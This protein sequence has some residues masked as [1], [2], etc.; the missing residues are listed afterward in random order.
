MPRVATC[1]FCN[2]RLRL[3]DDGLQGSLTCPLC[4]AELERAAAPAPVETAAD[5][6]TISVEPAGKT[7]PS[8]AAHVEREWKYCPLCQGPLRAAKR[9]RPPVRRADLEVNEDQGKTRW[10]LAALI[11]FGGLAAVEGLWTLFGAVI[12]SHRR[13][14]PLLFLVVISALLFGAVILIR[15]ARGEPVNLGGV[16]ISGFGLFA[17]V[18]LIGLLLVAAFFM[19]LFMLCAAGSSTGVHG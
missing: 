14:P 18:C 19:F 12:G 11:V 5:P 16:V 15:A 9:K 10:G 13:A 8:C 3:A 4:L 17:V 2:S 7:C 6:G 1:R